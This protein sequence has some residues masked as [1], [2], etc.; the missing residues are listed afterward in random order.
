MK[1]KIQII[2]IIIQQGCKLYISKSRGGIH[3]NI[4]IST[5]VLN[6]DNNNNNNV[7][8]KPCHHMS[9][10]VLFSSSFFPVEYLVVY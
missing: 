6:I 7:Y 10:N 3:K 9:L 1:I 8:F 2:I 4:N 5:N